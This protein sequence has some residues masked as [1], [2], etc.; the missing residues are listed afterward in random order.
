MVLVKLRRKTSG[1]LD[2]LSPSPGIYRDPL[3]CIGVSQALV[4]ILL[5]WQSKLT[6][7]KSSKD[8]EFSHYFALIF[9]ILIT[10][11][12]LT[13]INTQLCFMLPPSSSFFSTSFQKNHSHRGGGWIV[14]GLC[15][16]DKGGAVTNL[17]TLFLS[18]GTP[19]PRARLPLPKAQINAFSFPW[20]P[21]RGRREP[22]ATCFSHT[23]LFEIVNF[24]LLLSHESG[25]GH[26]LF[27][28]LF[29]YF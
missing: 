13:Q 10:L 8:L 27:I 23:I 25:F 18:A 20:Q 7:R 1:S 2:S 16:G 12:T 15:P 19:G 21:W 6:A 24:I 17:W 3:L 11:S 4:W 9:E 28:Y 5:K 14:R 22:N 26:P 29:V